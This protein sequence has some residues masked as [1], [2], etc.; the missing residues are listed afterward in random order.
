MVSVLRGHGMPLVLSSMDIFMKAKA[1]INLYQVNSRGSS[2]A[3]TPMVRTETLEEVL[4]LY[5]QRWI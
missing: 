1:G 5:K 2:I 3:R 4:D